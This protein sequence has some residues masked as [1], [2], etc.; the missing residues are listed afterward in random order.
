MAMIDK[1]ANPQCNERLVYLRSG[2]LYPVDTISA[3]HSQQATH[4]F[5]L[6]EPCSI[7]FKLQFN[8][9]IEPRVVPIL[10]QNSPPESS[11]SE[12]RRVRCIF[13]N[14]QRSQTMDEND[15]AENE[16]EVP[17]RVV[18]TILRAQE[19]KRTHLRFDVKYR[20]CT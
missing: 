7:K 15:D 16:H 9:Q 5:W 11:E 10:T 18:P 12:Y 17:D 3:S 20:T 13:I 6:C 2:V 8:D 4:F 14:R 19:L 1:C